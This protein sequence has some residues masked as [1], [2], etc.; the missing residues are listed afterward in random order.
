MIPQEAVQAAHSAI[1]E[2]N[3]DDC[4]DPDWRGR[5]VKAVEAAAPYMPSD[6]EVFV[7]MF[8]EFAVNLRVNN[9]TDDPNSEGQ[10][11]AYSFAAR[12]LR[13]ALTS[14]YRSQA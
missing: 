4:L 11:E 13:V 3:L 8:D 7:R 9:T 1:C 5:C 10:A 12:Q 2:Q 6:L 14:P